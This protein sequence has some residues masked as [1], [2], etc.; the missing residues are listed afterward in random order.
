MD[1]AKNCL[2]VTETK[3]PC[4]ERASAIVKKREGTIKYVRRSVIFAVP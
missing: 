4:G 1:I 3:D 2:V